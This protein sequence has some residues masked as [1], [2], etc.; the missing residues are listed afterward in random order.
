MVRDDSYSRAIVQALGA[1]E[2]YGPEPLLEDAVTR[3]SRRGL[4]LGESELI[5][6]LTGGDPNALERQR[7]H[8]QLAKWDAQPQPDA[9]WAGGTGPATSTRRER[10]LTLLGFSAEA[11]Q[12]INHAIPPFLVTDVSI[13][14]PDWEPWYTAERRRE[15]AF[16]WPAYERV[17]RRKQLDPEAVASIDAVTTNIVSR[18]ADPAAR[19][20]YQS[21]GL[22]VG[23]VQ[24]GKT[25][26]FT[27]VIAKAI[28]AGYRLII[29]LTGTIE[30][31]R[32][33]TQRRL[34]ME[35][36]GEENILGGRDRNDPAAVADIDYVG[37]GDRDWA[38]G[39]FVRHG[40]DF[41]V[42]PGV[43]AIRR[44]TGRTEDYKLLR[45]GLSALDFRSGNELR[46]PRQPVWHAENLYDTD[47]RIAVVKKNK[48]V[49]T[50]LVQDLRNVHARLDEIPTLII[51]DEADQASVN[52]VNPRKLSAER[53]DRT[54]INGLIAQLLGE[55]KR[56]QYVGYTATPFANVFVSPDDSE[57]I[58]PK[59]FIISLTPSPKYMGGRDFHDLAGIAEE[60][61]GNPAVSNEAA[62]VRNLRAVDDEFDLRTELRGALDA[63]VLSGAIK[64][65]RQAN[66]L[67]LKFDHHTMLVHESVRT[68]EHTVAAERIRAVWTNAAYSSPAA[69]VR[70]GHLLE[71]DFRRVSSSRDW[72]ESAD[73]PAT[74][75][76]LAPFVGQALDRIN[77]A[78]D[79]VVIVNGAKESEYTQVDFQK[80]QVWRILVGGAKLSRGFTVEGLTITY[81]RRRA[82]Q[83]DSLM[84]MGRWFGYRAG[85]RD[86][87]RL[88]IARNVE[89]SQGRPFDLYEAFQAV[90]EDEEE[91]RAQ[92][93]KFAEL[94][95]DGQPLVRPSEVPPL[96]FQQL[97][98]LKPTSPNKMYNAELELLG[99]GGV[100][101]DFPRQPDRGNGAVN[102]EHF[103]AVSGWLPRLGSPI[104]FEYL[105][106]ASGR[107]GTFEA[108]TVI[109]AAD[110]MVD[111]LSRFHWVAGFSFEPTLE[112]ISL[113]HREG[114]LDDWAVVLPLL[115]DRV[116]RAVEGHRIPVLRRTRRDG[117]RGG[118]SGSSFRQRDTVLHIAGGTER[119]G[120]ANAESLR[121][122]TRGA[123]LLS[124]AADPAPGPDR[125]PNGLP[126]PAAAAD[127]ATLFS[128]VI[129]KDAA[130]RGRIGFRVRDRSRPH[131]AIVEAPKLQ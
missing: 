49:L 59:D 127:I 62:F 10:I 39:R 32:A 112:M 81:Y 107:R 99:E 21:K 106:P 94:D 54:A 51:D 87:V 64:L 45:M 121:R 57:D 30:L 26:N 66:D 19:E 102:R 105:D 89:D 97:P 113:A 69:A 33:Q 85:Y 79:P 13:V 42:N 27:G 6:I 23:H 116:F 76:E 53:R 22:V 124:F 104:E 68:A 3:L 120:G 15:H 92:L 93:Q 95:E 1:M 43:P 110:D 80:D 71:S 11:S 88:Y 25:A 96:V 73:L 38:A 86:L 37:D 44:L 123:F 111:V 115:K 130:P 52:T 78:R 56:A 84:Q 119:R 47:V 65:W 46:D 55:V 74:F 7:F 35:L 114:K 2:D 8:Q 41:S 36:I 24:S 5:E 9:E 83:A 90:V 72:R 34:D 118:F 67:S 50:K 98:W 31:L 18:L 91:F 4:E 29:V 63:F 58:F 60:D 28:D 77:A 117:T 48:T 108:R 125:D 20:P 101:K 100:L 128:I 12:S 17:L 16:Y 122:A 82:L 131:Q 61:R 126:E 70:L 40:H 109:V 129:P 14:D 75:D 103:D